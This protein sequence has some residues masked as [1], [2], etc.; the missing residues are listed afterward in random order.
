[1]DWHLSSSI[2]LLI[3]GTEEGTEVAMAEEK[4][5]RRGILPVSGNEE[6]IL[7]GARLLAKFARHLLG[8]QMQYVYS[9]TTC[10]IV[11]H[12]IMVTALVQGEG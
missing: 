10:P 3:F 9:M 4:M 7:L 1:M 5:K 8:P 2:A 6:N 11:V 12:G